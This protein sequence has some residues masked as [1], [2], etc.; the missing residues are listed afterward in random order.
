MIKAT[1]SSAKDFYSLLS[2]LLKVTDEIILNF[3]ED[4]IFSRYLTDDKV[5]MVIFKIP[6]EYL[7]DYTIDK[8]L[9]IK[10]NIND[11][12]KILGKAKSKSATVTLEETEAGLK[13]T[14]RDEKTGTR[15]N[16]YIK[17]EKTSIDQ[18]TE[19]KVN[20]SVT[21]T[22]DG[23]VLKDIARDLSLVGEEVEISADENTVTLS[24]EEAGRTYKSL[25]KQDKP[26]KS[27]N[28]ESPS[29]A[30]YSIE[31]LKDVFKVTS[32]SQNVTVG[33]GNNIPMKIEVPTDSGGQLIFWI[34][35]RL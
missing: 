4:S 10:I 27:L 2:G 34:A 28:V 3:T 14:V 25:L 29:K 19:P 13:V 23:D 18:L 26:L 21:F 22:T 1:Y 33:F 9:G 24:T 6:K 12:K 7:E 20:L 30:V 17:G 32:I 15:S 35:P 31:V 8:P 5:L 16:I 11:L